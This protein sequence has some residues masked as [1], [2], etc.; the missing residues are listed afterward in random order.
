MCFRVPS[1]GIFRQFMMSF[2]T[3]IGWL[4]WGQLP[5]S[6]LILQLNF[7]TYTLCLHG[8]FVTPGE[9]QTVREMVPSI[10]RS[11]DTSAATI[12][13][14]EH[15]NFTLCL[16]HSGVGW[17]DISILQDGRNH[18][19]V[20]IPFSYAETVVAG[21]ARPTCCFTACTTANNHFAMIPVFS[22][23]ISWNA[24]RILS[25][26]HLRPV[27]LAN[28]ILGDWPSDVAFGECLKGHL[29]HS[30]T[31]Q[32]ITVLFDLICKLLMWFH[33]FGWWR[34]LAV[35]G[36]GILHLAAVT[37][38]ASCFT[39]CFCLSHTDGCSIT[40]EFHPVCSP[41]FFWWRCHLPF[42]FLPKEVLWPFRF[43][44]YRTQVTKASE[45]KKRS[46][47]RPLRCSVKWDPTSAD[48]QGRQL[49]PM[50]LQPGKRPLHL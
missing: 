1:S 21:I 29:V 4:H 38:V 11:L 47:G 16:G 14:L 24:G 13:W 3:F 32:C 23:S 27:T 31:I 5:S 34:F 18:S 50:C 12:S 8:Y 46:A 17:C 30:A 48:G 7:P 25:F 22:Y 33:C 49:H 20:N 28:Y 35:I 15:P 41:L 39:C 2:H 9:V 36:Y 19:A 26:I 10:W 6:G 44:W 45:K 40:S 43:P 37:L 42:A